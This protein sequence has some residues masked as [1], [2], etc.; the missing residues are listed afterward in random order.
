M[1]DRLSATESRQPASGRFAASARQRCSPVVTIPA[2]STWW[3]S[4]RRVDARRHAQ[5]CIVGTKAYALS[6]AMGADRYEIDGNTVHLYLSDGASL[7]G[8]TACIV[9]GSILGDGEFAVI[10]DGDEEIAC[11]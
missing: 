4:A 1:T 7:R 9:S 2:R 10:N 11:D 3:P 5:R 8:S 6:S